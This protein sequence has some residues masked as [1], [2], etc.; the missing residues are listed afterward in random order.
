[1]PAVKKNKGEEGLLPACRALAND[2]AKSTAMPATKKTGIT[3]RMNTSTSATGGI[4][5]REVLRKDMHFIRRSL[6]SARVAIPR[7]LAI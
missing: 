3:K 5:T 1:M 4:G 6:A 2:A 7:T